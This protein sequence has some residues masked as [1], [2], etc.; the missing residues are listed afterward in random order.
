MKKILIV[1]T[2]LYNGGAEKS[3]VNL[4]NELPFDKYQVDL[5]LFM[6]KGIFLKQVPA[7]VNI[8][9]TPY[10]IEKLYGY[11]LNFG[12]LFLMKYVGGMVAKIFTRSDSERR[13]FRWKWFYSRVIP[14]LDTYYDVALG[15]M[16]CEIIYYLDEKVNAGRK[17]GWVHN[18]Y[19]S[20]KYPHKYDDKH[21]ANL[22]ALVSISDTCVNILKEE[23]PEI[24]NK[25]Y[26][27]QNITS[28]K[29]IEKRANEFYPKEYNEKEVNLIS[30][31]R[32]HEQKGFDL[33]AHAASI[34]KKRGISFN[35]FIIGGGDEGKKKLESLIRKE[36][37]SDCFKLLGTRENP[38]PYIKNATI[39][40]QPSRYEGKSVVLDEAKI[41]SVP[42][43][44]TAYP[45]VHDQIKEDKEGVIVSLT[46]EG[47]AKGI[48]EVI[49]HDKIREK[50]IAYLKDYEYGNQNEV[51][52]YINLIENKQ[53]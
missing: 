24:K 50:L 30:I 47:I 35:W 14:K 33:A 11:K 8:I 29:T 49:I 46:P 31:G 12:K 53:R 22:D 15:Y 36:N 51:E 17:I 18:D 13:A 6:K 43:I 42:I 3:L 37:I 26:C 28:S 9:D 16:P 40:V 48:E 20:S 32:L 34:M 7:E 21:F 45:T 39:F 25:I 44:A 5:L 23:F 4:L 10:E 1:M 41:L 2:S 38:Y 52:K 19:R 27:L